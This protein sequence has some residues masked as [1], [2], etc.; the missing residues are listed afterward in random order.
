MREKEFGISWVAQNRAI[1]KNFPEEFLEVKDVHEIKLPEDVLVL[2]PEMFGEYEIL[3]SEGNPVLKAESMIRAKYILYSNR[4][5]PKSIKIPNNE[6]IIKET[7]KRY[8]KYLDELLAQIKEE[9]EDAFPN[10]KQLY[11]VTNYIFASLN[12][13]RY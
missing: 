8:E 3:D 5:K 7:V 12:L 11:D 10:S 13:K 2:G 4:H 6:E 9:F 1:I